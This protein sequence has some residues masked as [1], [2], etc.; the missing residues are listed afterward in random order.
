MNE[1]NKEEA[2]EKI[3]FLRAEIQSFLKE[4]PEEFLGP[5][6]NYLGSWLLSSAIIANTTCEEDIGKQIDLAIEGL[7]FQLKSHPRIKMMRE[8]K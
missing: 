6:I 2:F 1:L 8:T 5:C 7:K 4:I 3:E